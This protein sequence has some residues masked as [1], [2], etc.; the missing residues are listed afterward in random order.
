MRAIA[1]LLAMQVLPTLAL[2][3]PAARFS[4]AG[5]LVEGAA[6]SAD[7]RYR[8]AADLK[9]GDDR[10]QGDRFSLDARL[11]V[12]DGVKAATTACTATS[13]IFRNGFE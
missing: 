12:G 9:R 7:G 3:A 6:A 2:A 1:L 4:G 10:Q 8:L 13:D 11:T 5:T